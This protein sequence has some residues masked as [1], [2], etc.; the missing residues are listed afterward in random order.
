MKPVPE[1]ER[2]GASPQRSGKAEL[3][4]LGVDWSCSRPLDCLDESML[5]IISFSYLG[6]LV[7][8][9]NSSPR[10]CDGVED[11]FGGFSEWEDSEG[12]GLL[13]S[14]TTCLGDGDSL[15]S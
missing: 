5:M 9:P 14:P 15:S 13:L 8:V 3:A 6:T 11:S 12:L 1:V 7:L 10:A 4:H 2:G